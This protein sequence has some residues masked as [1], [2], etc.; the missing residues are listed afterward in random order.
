MSHVNTINPST[1]QPLQ[2]ASRKKKIRLAMDIVN[3][4]I[5]LNLLLISTELDKLK[6]LLRKK[7]KGRRWWVKP[8]ITTNIRQ[9]FGAHR[10]LFEYFRI[11]DHE[12]FFKFT[13]MTV[14]Q[15]DYLNDLLKPRLLKRS[16]RE[17]LPT[18]IAVTLRLVY[19]LYLYNHLQR[20]L[21][22]SL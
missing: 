11:S 10:K 13:R 1:I 2:V 17:P 19:N 15:F 8:H 14:Q 9:N 22:E 5:Y 6:L 4:G 12:E 3:C 20:M 18:E 7:H 16:R 21:Y